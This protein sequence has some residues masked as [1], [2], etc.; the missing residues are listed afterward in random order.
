MSLDLKQ[1]TSNAI[2]YQ[3]PLFLSAIVALNETVEDE[4]DDSKANKN[5]L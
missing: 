1:S 2:S 5:T 4:D 3:S